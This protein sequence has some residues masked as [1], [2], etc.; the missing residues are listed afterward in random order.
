MDKLT[1]IKIKYDDGTYSDEIPISVL[2]ENVE[3]DNTHTLVDV[4]GS[5]NVGVTGTIQDQI[6]KLFNEKVGMA[7][8]QN[9]VASQLNEDVST[10]LNNNV[11]PVGSAV[12]VDSSLT[13]SGAAADAKK[14]GGLKE[15]LNYIAKINGL[16][17]KNLVGME[18]DVYYPVYIPIGTSFTMSTEDGTAI[19][20]T[21]L[22]LNIYDENKTK[23]DNWNFNPRFSKRTVTHSKTT[24]GRY[25]RWTS[26]PV[27]NVQVELGSEATEYVPYNKPLDYSALE[28]WSVN[29]P[30]YDEFVYRKNLV[31]SEA[32]VFYPVHI[33]PG[34]TFTMSTSDGSTLAS[35]VRL[36]MYDK[37]K[38][39]LSDY[40]TFRTGTSERTVTQ[41]AALGTAYYM[42]WDVK[43]PVPFQVEI[44][45]KTSYVP[46]I[47]N[48][49][50]LYERFA[51]LKE[52][53]KEELREELKE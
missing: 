39:E 50:Y 24:S 15:N 47:G 22:N 44:G 49:K 42:K 53:L 5:I 32:G 34:T 28:K 35:S 19:G 37:D 14:T 12:I 21:D 6:S 1:A 38:Q 26:T 8:L 45:A 31:G 27:K 16:N 51:E 41:T 4:L 30:L 18:A 33:V 52:E 7:Q 23:I 43:L 20:Q 40:W 9:Y 17:Y 10:W 48:T 46:Y 29:S 3:W 25:L 2:S 11:N 13:V 36:Q